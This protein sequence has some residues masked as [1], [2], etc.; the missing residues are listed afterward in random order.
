APGRPIR[1]TRRA[2]LPIPRVPVSFYPPSQFFQRLNDDRRQPIVRH[3]GNHHPRHRATIRADYRPTSGRGDGVHAHPVAAGHAQP[4]AAAQTR[5]HHA[6][7]A[8]AAPTSV[9]RGASPRRSASA[10]RS[11]PITAAAFQATAFTTSPRTA[12]DRKSTRLNS[13]HVKNSY[14]VFCLKK[15][16][17]QLKHKQ[18]E[19]QKVYIHLLIGKRKYYTLAITKMNE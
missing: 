6:P 14:A 17:D 13:S 18:I 3:P 8:I 5:A 10:V 15:K 19:Q 16:L 9:P 4:L 1:A 11:M 2:C 12:S 7:A